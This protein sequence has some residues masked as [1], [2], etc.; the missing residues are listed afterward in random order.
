MKYL[1]ERGWIILNGGK[2]G[3]EEGEWTNRGKKKRGSRSV[4]DFGIV[5]WE[6]WERVK[7]F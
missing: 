4:V 1:E 3:D 6:A 5:N 2:E 7:R